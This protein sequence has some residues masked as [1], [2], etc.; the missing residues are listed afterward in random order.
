MMPKMNRV[1]PADIRNRAGAV[2]VIASIRGSAHGCGTCSPT[3]ATPATNSAMLQP[4][5]VGS[6]TASAM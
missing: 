2:G 3:A 4:N 5:S 6:Q 1:H